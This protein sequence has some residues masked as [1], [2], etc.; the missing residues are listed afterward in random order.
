MPVHHFGN[1]NNKMKKLKLISMFL[2]VFATA[3]NAQEKSGFGFFTDRD[4]Y[5]SG[6][7][8]LAKVFLPSGNLSR[9]VHLD[10]VN[11]VG[12][13]I[14]DVSLEIKDNQADGY[15]QLPDSLSSGTYLLRAYLSNS[16]ESGKIIRELWIVNRFNGLETTDGIKKATNVQLLPVQ[17]SNE[18]R[19]AG[20]ENEVKINS[21]VQAQIQL[22]ETLMQ[23]MDGKLLL[24]VAQIVPTYESATFLINSANGRAGLPEVKGIIRTGIVTDRKTSLP[25]AN[26]TVYFTI[27]DSIPGFQ[28]YITG[29]DG[30]YYFLIDKYFGTVPTVIQ[31]YPKNPLQRLKITLDDSFADVGKLPDFSIQPFPEEFRRNI[32]N[33]MNAVTFQKVFGYEKLSKTTAPKKKNDSYAYYGI[34]TQTIDPQLF[35]DLPNFNEISKELL[36]G[37]KFRNHNNEPTLQVFNSPVRNF[38]NEQPLILI[39]GIPIRDL[40][41]IKDMGTTDIDRVDICQNERY[42][43]DLRFTGV[44]AI[45]TTKSDYSNL[46]ESDQLLNLKLEAIQYPARLAK[47]IPTEPSIPDLRQV[48]YWN[49]SAEPAKTISVKFDTSTIQGSF[50]IVV[51]GRTTDGTL[52]FAEKQFEV[53]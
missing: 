34:P 9:I 3:A 30:R 33:S 16:F 50:K 28:Y 20:I 53:K 47:S 32:V 13:Q 27:P 2:I 37:V 6:E 18:I 8:V 4:V 10:L 43:G 52:I 12:K 17:K 24:S 39:D 46:P 38:F 48:I 15:F 41:V 31:C 45:Y 21:A 22:D 44:V 1:K 29:N 25:V 36:P 42:Y 40:N 14:S 19:I 49:P 11:K 51:R 35:I 5:V 23:K 26:A 7:I